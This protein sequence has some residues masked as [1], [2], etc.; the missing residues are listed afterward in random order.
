MIHEYFQ[1]RDR[2]EPVWDLNE[3]L[4]VELKHDNK[5]SL[6]TRWDETIIAMKTQPGKNVYHRQLQQSEQLKP[7]L[8]LCIQDTVQTG[9]SRLK[10]MVVRH[11]EQKFR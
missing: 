4:N 5:Q 7:L 8:S 9:E 3:M 1:A 10:M 2:D 6:K 11:L